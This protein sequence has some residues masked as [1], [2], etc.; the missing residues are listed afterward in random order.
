MLNWKKE[1][2]NLYEAKSLNGVVYSIQKLYSGKKASYFLTVYPADSPIGFKELQT[3]SSAKE[4]AQKLDSKLLKIYEKKKMVR[5]VS[6]LV[7]K[8]AFEMVLSQ[9]TKEIEKTKKQIHNL[10]RSVK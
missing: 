6:L 10:C 4:C 9:I 5:L 1:K 3:L 7:N 8:E 2:T